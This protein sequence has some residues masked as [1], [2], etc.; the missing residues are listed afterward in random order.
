MLKPN[1]ARCI[2]VSV[3]SCTSARPGPS[4][5]SASTSGGILVQACT[6]DWGIR[7]SYSLTPQHTHAGDSE[8]LSQSHW[9]WICR[10]ASFVRCMAAS[11]VDFTSIC[12]RMILSCHGN[13][14]HRSV[15][16]P[17][18]CAH[19]AK[20][21]TA[22]GRKKAKRSHS[23]GARNATFSQETYRLQS[24]VRLLCFRP[25]VPRTRPT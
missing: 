11:P 8:S 12:T 25:R 2:Q 7:R 17:P 14:P 19:A 24:T 9:H 5:P 10:P 3:V 20:R 21:G 4:I 16:I 23:L 18:S 6:A 1:P 13:T 15:P 22:P